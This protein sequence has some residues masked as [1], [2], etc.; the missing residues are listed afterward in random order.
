MWTLF[1]TRKVVLFS[2]VKLVKICTNLN[3]SSHNFSTARASCRKINSL[4]WLLL[5]KWKCEIYIF[6]DNF[7]FWC[8]YLQN[9]KI[10]SLICIVIRIF[11]RGKK[12][13]KSLISDI[14]NISVKSR[15][16][17]LLSANIICLLP[18]LELNSPSR[19]Q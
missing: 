18:N 7:D 19:F 3:F 14:R 15:M 2:C 8:Y 13:V 12:K 17:I 9:Q 1:L 5:Q 10:K 16:H 6:R 4:C 11:L